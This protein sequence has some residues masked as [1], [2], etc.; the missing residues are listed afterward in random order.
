[1]YTGFELFRLKEKDVPMEV[2]ELENKMTEKII[3]FAWEPRGPRFGIIHGD[4]PRPDISF[5]TMTDARSGGA[6]KLRLL[7][8]LKVRPL[9]F[10][11]YF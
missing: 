2:L 4:G 8:T 5:Y 11:F 9:S 7:G 3:A 6:N 10:F 1:M